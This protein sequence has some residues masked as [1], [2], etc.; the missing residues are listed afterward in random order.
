MST[1]EHKEKDV[2]CKDRKRATS[3][4]VRGKSRPT[5][6]YTLTQLHQNTHVGKTGTRMWGLI[7]VVLKC[8]VEIQNLIKPLIV[9]SSILFPEPFWWSIIQNSYKRHVQNLTHDQFWKRCLLGVY[10]QSEGP[11]DKRHPFICQLKHTHCSQCLK[12]TW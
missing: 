8:P 3:T 12:A 11:P 1:G 4:K 10:C 2:K 6:M 9:G 5:M 7:R